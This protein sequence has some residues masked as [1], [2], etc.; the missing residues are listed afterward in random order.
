MYA[1]KKYID[2]AGGLAPE[3]ADV[4]VTQAD[5][6]TF[7][8]RRGLFP[9]NPRV[10]EGGIITVTLKPPKEPGERADV[11]KIITESIAINGKNRFL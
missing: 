7:K 10:D 6:A 4:F 9:T 2:R 3:T 8:L 11:G 1:D 5:G